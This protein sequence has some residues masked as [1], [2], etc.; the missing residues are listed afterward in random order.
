MMYFHS[1]LDDFTRLISTGP[2]VFWRILT[3][4]CGVPLNHLLMVSHVTINVSTLSSQM[5]LDSNIWFT[6][7]YMS[8]HCYRSSKLWQ[9]TRSIFGPVLN[10]PCFPSLFHYP[11]ISP[12][13]HSLPSVCT[14]KMVFHT[15]RTD[16]DLIRGNQ[17]PA[18]EKMNGMEIMQKNAT[19]KCY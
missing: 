19:L 1:F 16:T 3:S 2:K 15:H 17:S 4:S 13:L 10:V 11:F 14:D 7:S 18:G 6:I 8:K 5:W 12:R 9:T